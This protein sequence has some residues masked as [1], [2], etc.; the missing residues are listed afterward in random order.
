MNI[1]FS[2]GSWNLEELTYAYS[3]RFPELPEFSQKSDCIESRKNEQSSQGYDYISLLAKKPYGPGTKI[4]TRC[5]FDRYGAPLIMIADKLEA[6]EQGILRYRNYLEVVLYE[7]GINVWKLWDD[8]G[9]IRWKKLLH[10]RFPVK[11]VE[12]HD[13]SVLVEK[14]ML[15]IEA[16]GHYAELR[17][18]DMFPSWYGGITACEGIN[19]FYY[20]NIEEKA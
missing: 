10:V 2:S 12:A 18:E 19:R 14:D 6:D 5:G 3:C 1:S 11:A 16:D 15:K 9:T 20:L 13:L 8:Q 17:V 7:D 4:S